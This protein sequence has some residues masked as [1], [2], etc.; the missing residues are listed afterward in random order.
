TFSR[1]AAREIA[2]RVEAALVA[3]SESA[4]HP[5]AREIAHRLEIVGAFD[6]D[7]VARRARA[8]LAGLGDARFDTLHGVARRVVVDHAAELEQPLGA[9]IL[10]EHEV[11]ALGFA[12]VDAALGDALEAG[13][14]R[15]AAARALVSATAGVANARVRV[16]ALADRLDEEG[17]DVGDLA[18]ADHAAD[19]RAAGDRLRVIAAACASR[20]SQA[21]RAPAAELSRALDAAPAG[22]F[23]RAA[24]AP[25]AEL[26]AARLPREDKRTDAERD[27]E[28]LR[29][30]LPGK[31]SRAQQ[32]ERLGAWLRAAP[33]LVDRERAVVALLA[34]ARA[35]IGAAKREAGG[36][37]FGDLL[38]VAR[39]ALLLRPDV[40]RSARERVSALLVDEFQ[41]TSRV[42]RD[43]V[44]LLRERDRSGRADGARPE[45]HH[46]E[47]H[48]LFVVGDRKQS[49]YGFRGADVAVFSRTCAELCGAPAEAALALPPSTAPRAPAVA[50]FVALRTSRRSGGRVLDLVN[51]LSERDFA[52]GRDAGA[53]PRPF[54][55]AYGPG[56]RLEAMPGREAA[57]RVTIVIDDGAS[58]DDADALLASATGAAR[59][60]HVAAAAVALA[61]RRDGRRPRDVAVLA[62]RR[63]TI[64]FVELA[65]TRLEL[66]Y[67]VAG[68]ALY[69]TFEV[70]DASALL[71]LLLDPRDRLALATVLRGP[72]VALSDRGLLALSPP[73]RGLSLEGA[74]RRGGVDLDADD[75]AKLDAF[76]ATF[77]ALRPALLA[78]TPGE[79][80]A[81]AARHFELERVI[82]ALPR[83]EARIANLDRLVAIARRRG[84]TLA[85]FSRWLAAR[86]DEDT[87]EAEAAVFSAED[88]AVRLTTVHASKGLDFPVV[89]LV[90]LA[91][92]PRSD[93]PAVGFAALDERP[94][95]V[96][97][98]HAARPSTDRDDDGPVLVQSRAMVAAQAEGRA[99]DAA[100]RRRLTYVAVTRAAD[101]LILVGSA[102]PP[103]A[104]SAWGTIAAGVDDGS[105]LAL[106]E[107]V[108]AK[109]LLELAP[110]LPRAAPTPR[111][112]APSAPV[113]PV[114]SPA[115]AVA[116]ATTPLAVFAGCARRFR[117][118]HLVGLEEPI[119][120]GALRDDDFDPAAAGDVDVGDGADDPRALGRAAHRVL[121]RWP[122]ARFGA[123]TDPR[124][125]SRA[126]VRAS[127]GLEGESDAAQAVARAIARFLSSPYAARLVAEGATLGREVA[128]AVDVPGRADAPALVLKGAID[129]LVTWPSGAVDVVDYKLAS[130]TRDAAGRVDLARHAFQLRAYALVAARGGAA[131]VAAAV[132]HLAGDG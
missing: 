130:P 19:A 119:A 30:A 110:K 61:V 93:A 111:A 68:R 99:R 31:G 78:S 13:G 2:R 71:R 66:P 85:G 121:E 69:D 3:I 57:G 26:L 122:A 64:P 4:P 88:D 75:R 77:D 34:D 42:Q 44:Y 123:P 29:D 124:E 46:L 56:E 70:R 108:R 80:V 84:G 129:L 11:S 114:T 18:L 127:L 74:R 6:A 49:I 54:E 48:G 8:A 55:I 113:R 7:D 117:L 81:G 17:L 39:D 109:D 14:D 72:A 24:A 35:R 47:A 107:A 50:D 28:A 52:S 103:R 82:A 20:A 128:F 98:H 131:D 33:R 59:E 120:R 16:L 43:I 112:E 25:L 15:A 9:P 23:P 104:A 91:A 38:R 58:P 12:A 22:A 32:A 89:V 65:L 62:R 79:A 21:V 86:V 1:A 27:L 126:L 36:L 115:R 5:F 105:L 102:N 132:V 60:G 101:E 94:T 63:S 67:V 37:G 51:A 53:P 41:D 95:F 116:V 73:G 90:D 96:L 40:A 125:V 106:C 10:D 92:E 87:D 100:E 83:A 76:R 118:R 97:R 45:P